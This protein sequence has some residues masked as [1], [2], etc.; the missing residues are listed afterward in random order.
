MRD[1]G[2]A[3]LRFGEIKLDRARAI[4]GSS[5][6]VPGFAPGING[7]S[8]IYRQVTAYESW[9]QTHFDE[10]LLGDPAIS[11]PDAD[12]D[13]DGR[14][15]LQEL[16]SSVPARQSGTPPI[17]RIP[18]GTVSLTLRSRPSNKAIR[19]RPRSIGGNRMAGR[20]QWFRSEKCPHP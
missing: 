9:L 20:R 3:A 19:P 12:P 14:E 8:F 17:N 15:N 4:H 18:T 10:T 1:P 13:G 6:G 5:V 11:G 7:Q 16:T 2:H